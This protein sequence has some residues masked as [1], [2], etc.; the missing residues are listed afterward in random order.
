[1]NILQNDFLISAYNEA[2]LAAQDE[3][4]SANDT[5][6]HLEDGGNSF[7]GHRWVKLGGRSS[8]FKTANR[9]IRSQF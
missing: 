4:L 9:N 2:R 7:S 8:D 1:M 5:V 3:S 6:M